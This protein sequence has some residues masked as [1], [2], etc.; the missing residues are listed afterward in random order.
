MG[1]G[2]KYRDLSEKELNSIIE[3]V[4]NGKVCR[5]STDEISKQEAVSLCSKKSIYSAYLVKMIPEEYFDDKEFMQGFVSAVRPVQ[6]YSVAIYASNRLKEDPEF[7]SFC[8]D[9]HG[10]FAVSALAGDNDGESYHSKIL[11]D[12]KFVLNEIYKTRRN[13]VFQNGKMTEYISEDKA[14]KILTA[15]AE[16]SPVIRDN[17]EL[18]IRS[19]KIDPYT[20]KFV[21]KSIANDE[22]IIMAFLETILEKEKEYYLVQLIDEPSNKKLKKARAL[23]LKICELPSTAKARKLIYKKLALALIHSEQ[24]TLIENDEFNLV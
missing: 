16:F 4:R 13:E 20:Y 9:K 24:S 7:A 18:M 23:C 21:D 17:K 1:L 19:I 8:I 6:N 3:D 12:K 2:I 15:F 14:N 22:E 10:A 5:F 11:L